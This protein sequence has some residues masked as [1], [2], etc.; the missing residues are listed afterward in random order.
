MPCAQ[1]SR[2]YDRHRRSLDGKEIGE[3]P[4]PH[5]LSSTSHAIGDLEDLRDAASAK[6]APR[7]ANQQQYGGLVPRSVAF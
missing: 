5:K 1:H 3:K 2:A 7:K 4:E 6:V